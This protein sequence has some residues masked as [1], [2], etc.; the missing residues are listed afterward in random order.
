MQSTA[1]NLPPGYQ[2]HIV[3]LSQIAGASSSALKENANSQSETVEPPRP[4]SAN[5]RPAKQQ[6]FSMDSDEEDEDGA[7]GG[8][9]F[10]QDDERTSRDTQILTVD[11]ESS[12]GPRPKTG[13]K[14]VISRKAAVASTDI[15][16]WG[17]DGP[18]D[19]GE[20]PYFKAIDEWM[21]VLS[22]IVSCT[23]KCARPSQSN[24][25]RHSCILSLR[26]KDYIET[27]SPFSS[28]VLL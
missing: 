4:K 27:A 18:I 3:Q 5:Y 16:I 8:I 1:L 24:L 28:H 9:D 19:A 7:D 11:L 25:V 17:A 2:A 10:D 26:C 15:R 6:K 20:D 21:K 22:P 23:P 12:E 13:N 14:T